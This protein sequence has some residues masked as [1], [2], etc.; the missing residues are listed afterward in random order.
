MTVLCHAYDALMTVLCRSY[1][2]LMM[3]L[4]CSYDSLMMLLCHSYG[5]LLSCLWCCYDTLLSLLWLSVQCHRDVTLMTV[6]CHSYSSL[7]SFISHFHRHV[8]AT[9]MTQQQ[10]APWLKQSFISKWICCNETVTITTQRLIISLKQHI[11]RILFILNHNNVPIMCFN[12]SLWICSY[13]GN[14]NIGRKRFKALQ[15]CSTERV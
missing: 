8:C 14:D 13:Y 15:I 2:T 4:C 10:A 3:L 6:L 9:L 7:I 1:F 12:L 5:S 11:L